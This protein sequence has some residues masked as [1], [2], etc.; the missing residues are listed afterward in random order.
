[1]GKAKRE[2]IDHLDKR[3]EDAQARMAAIRAA[4]TRGVNL[5]QERESDGTDTGRS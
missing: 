3:L 4:V 5:L 2:K 1:M